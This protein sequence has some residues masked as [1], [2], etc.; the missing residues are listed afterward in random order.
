LDRRGSAALPAILA[1]LDSLSPV[2]RREA[3]SL[4]AAWSQ[5]LTGV[6]R[7]PDPLA[8]APEAQARVWWTRFQ[9]SRG[10]DF[11]LSYAERQ[12]QRVGA[13]DRTNA[14]G[15]LLELGTFA[16][17]G[18]Q[19]VLAA[20]ADR[21]AQARLTG[22]LSDLT[23]LPV[24][25]DAN[26]APG[27]VLRIT[28]AW[29][30]FWYAERLEFETLT[31]ERRATARFFESRYGR[32]VERALRGRLGFSRVTLR[33]VAIELRWRLPSSTLSSGLGGLVGTAI[34]IAFGG[35]PAL[36]RRRLRPKLLDLAG[37]L[38]PGLIALVSGWLV[39]LRVCSPTPSL[40]SDLALVLGGGQWLPL[41]ASAAVIA[42]GVS[43]FLRRPKAAT[44]IQL[45]RLEAESWVADRLRPGVREVLRHGAR[46]GVASLLAPLGFAGPVVLLASLVVE[47]PLGLK[48]MGQLTVRALAARDAPWL[49]AAVLT[50]VPL[51][52]GRR[53]ARGL[54]VRV[55]DL[56]AAPPPP[57]VSAASLD[58]PT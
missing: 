44:A 51:L 13:R 9:A 6:E 18:I 2:A 56:P 33:P 19:N 23:R 3:L 21:D 20:T 47:L 39:M 57:R 15:R 31:E 32:W 53:W 7:A 8:G 52:L 49:M 4:I 38:V 35:G 50:T 1:R 48:G 40:R 22:L 26:A 14:Y 54:L 42:A 36:R 11:R 58:S 34:A 25:A 29:Q 24:R 41:L 28:A 45:V 5:S 55:L 16:L 43:W 30:A 17:P 37:A 46:I 10:L 27:E 12:A